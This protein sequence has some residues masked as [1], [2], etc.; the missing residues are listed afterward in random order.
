MANPDGVTLNR[1]VLNRTA[2][3]PADA[4]ADPTKIPEGLAVDPAK[5]PEVKELQRVLN[6]AGCTDDVGKPLKMD[7]IFGPKTERALKEFQRANDLVDTGVVDAPTLRKLQGPP[8]A[9]AVVEPAAPTPAPAPARPTDAVV[10]AG[11]ARMRAGEELMRARVAG[12]DAA[13]KKGEA[14]D[15][16]NDANVQKAADTIGGIQGSIGEQRATIATARAGIQKDVAALQARTGRTEPEEMLLTG[17]K[18]QDEVLGQFDK[19]LATKSEA[20]DAA[21]GAVSDGIITA[22]ENRGLQNVTRALAQQEQILAVKA[23]AA[24]QVVATAERLGARVPAAATPAATSAAGALSQPQVNAAVAGVAEG[25]GDDKSKVHDAARIFAALD[26]KTPAQ[27]EQIK[28]AYHA[29][30]GKDGWDFDTNVRG[31]MHTWNK[32]AF[33]ALAAGKADD[34]RRLR[35][36]GA[37]KDQEVN[38]GTRAAAFE[39]P[40]TRTATAEPEI[41]NGSAKGGPRRGLARG[42]ANETAPAIAT[43]PPSAAAPAVV[44]PPPAAATPPVAAATPKAAPPKAATPPAAAPVPSDPVMLVGKLDALRDIGKVQGGRG[45]PPARTDAAVDLMK[46][47]TPPQIADLKKA[48]A[49]S[50]H[51]FDKEIRSKMSGYHQERLAALE[52]GDKTTFDSITSKIDAGKRLARDADQAMEGA[53]D[54]TNEAKLFKAL[55]A[56]GKDPMLKKIMEQEYTSTSMLRHGQS[57]DAALKSELS[58]DE[59]IRGQALWANKP[60]LANAAYAH[61]KLNPMSDRDLK[62]ATRFLNGANQETVDAFKAQYGTSLRSFVLKTLADSAQHPVAT[63]TRS[64]LRDA[65]MK[66]P[67]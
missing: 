35:A 14:Y 43:P 59:L 33:D 66:L 48:Y 52:K 37:V 22:G 47:M 12:A 13:D 7:S 54:G 49:A 50:G 8:M 4:A 10:G 11:R 9:P 42:P 39:E 24:D 25:V 58:G 64:Q 57:M 19:H 41:N 55:E 44:A 65:V 17:K 60:A 67:E 29:Q 34:F 31:K 45:A 3:R 21:L 38:E 2:N 20:M 26:G 30:F 51:D 18:A 28:V 16:V 36:E 27:L 46:D 15:V 5:K 40:A 62:E 23:D 53:L 6:D 63:T 32:Q 56:G 1:P 61:E